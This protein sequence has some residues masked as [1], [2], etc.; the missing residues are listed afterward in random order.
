MNILREI[1]QVKNF[2]DLESVIES[3]RN[4][5]L[6]LIIIKNALLNLTNRKTNEVD[7]RRIIQLINQ[8]DK[9]TG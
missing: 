9:L 2:N 4:E 3:N 7:Y 5:K 1:E 6:N 8:I